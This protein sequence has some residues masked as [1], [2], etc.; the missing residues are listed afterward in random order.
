MV[1]WT[2]DTPVKWGGNMVKG[3]YVFGI[4]VKGPYVHVKGSSIDK[5]KGF[6]VLYMQE[7]GMNISAGKKI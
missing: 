2:V 1:I 4:L 5:E 6:V 7:K 3:L